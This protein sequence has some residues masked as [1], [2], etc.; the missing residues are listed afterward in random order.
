MSF[1][2][3]INKNNMNSLFGDNLLDNKGKEI[4]TAD[5][6]SKKG[7]VIG[8]YFSAHWC[9]PCRAFTPKLAK[10]YNE[11]KKVGK[12][13]EV[14][15]VSSDS[16]EA[17]FKS[18]HGEMPWLAI[19]Y[20][21]DDNKEAC[22]EKYSVRGLPTLVLIDGE[23]GD[24]ISEEGRSVIEEFGAGAFPFSK[25]SIAECKKEKKEKKAK[26]LSDMGSL[27]FI[28]SLTKVSDPEANQN[29]ESAIGTSEAIAFSFMKG[30]N[31]RGSSVVLPKLLDCQKTLGKDKLGIILFPLVDMEQFGEGMK[32]TL[33][34]T[35]MVKPGEK[36]NEIVKKFEVISDEIDAPHVIVLAKNSDGTFKL[37]ADD[38]ARDIYFTG[39]GGFP[40]STEALD[41]LKAKEEA[42]KEEMKSKQKNLEFLDSNVVDKK[43]EPVP[44]SALQSKDVVGLYF[45]AHWCGPCRGFTPQL[46]KLYNECKEKS[47]S[48]EIVFISSDR[49]DEAFNEY[50]NE[51]PW[52]ALSFKERELKSNLSDVYEVQ[53]IPTLILL[54]GK[55]EM[56]TMDGRAAVSAGIESFPWDEAAMKKANQD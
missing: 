18:Y 47:K 28:G 3:H 55:G 40:W 9:P 34:D 17:D 36:V 53:G 46:A 41:A 26:A 49:S 48:F 6:S 22:S 56:I 7:S 21:N 23:T 31:D 52:C 25:S 2:T 24:T 16:S 37:V 5:I 1:R 29:L 11:L 20:D 44:L 42:A 12:D 14:I 54:S 43:G 8:L 32:S 27:S 4:K 13:F 51:M 50:F 35:P 30:S 15:F 10:E 38:A 39:V 45:S 33:C 19:P